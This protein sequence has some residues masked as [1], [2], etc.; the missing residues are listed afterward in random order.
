MCVYCKHK[1]FKAH[2]DNGTF[3]ECY[4]NYI[5]KNLIEWDEVVCGIIRVFYDTLK[6][7]SKKLG[8]K[9]VPKVEKLSQNYGDDFPM[10]TV[11]HRKAQQFKVNTKN[12]SVK[13]AALL[14]EY[15][16]VISFLYGG[17]KTSRFVVTQTAINKDNSIV[18]SDSDEDNDTHSR[19][20]TRRRRIEST[21]CN[22]Q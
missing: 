4:N 13:L 22:N 8:A 5:A 3:D 16:Y 20:P 18:I 1:E 21:V 19:P 9:G 11:F 2:F 10:V 17:N 6:E 12:V 7:I 14:K 15:D